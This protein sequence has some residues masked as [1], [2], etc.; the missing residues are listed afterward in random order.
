MIIGSFTDGR[1]LD[2]DELGFQFS[3]GGAP[4]SL[5][6]VK[7]ADS[8]GQIIWLIDE[9]REWVYQLNEEAFIRA[10]DAASGTW[11]PVQQTLQQQVAGQPAFRAQSPAQPQAPATPQPPMQ[12]PA[13][14]VQP[15]QPSVQPP[16]DQSVQP[17]AKPDDKSA[18]APKDALSA[19]DEMFEK[20]PMRMYAKARREADNTP[21]TSQ[22]KRRAGVAAGIMIA[23]LIACIIFMIKMM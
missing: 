17:Q 23:M 18:E 16:L 2:Y 13:A 22:Q 12:M 1:Q 5:A 9:Q 10:H 6:D 21:L 3:A 19:M 8:A 7:A 11:V 14:P 20:S 4:I 15:Q